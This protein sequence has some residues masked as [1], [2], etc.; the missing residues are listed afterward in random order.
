ME[1]YSPCLSITQAGHGHI[2]WH[3][4]SGAHHKEA[5]KQGYPTQLGRTASTVPL[6]SSLLIRI[7]FPVN[8]RANAQNPNTAWGLTRAPI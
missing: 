7:K 1:A 3:H 2:G 4:R 5:I 8:F 6:L